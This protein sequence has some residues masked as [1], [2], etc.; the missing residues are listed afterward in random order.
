M[1][2]GFEWPSGWRALGEGE[3]AATFEAELRRELSSDHALHGLPASLLAR[4]DDRDDFLFS[5]NDARVAQV[6]LTWRQEHTGEWPK[7]RIF[8]DLL[9]WR[10][11]VG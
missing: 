2:S 5:L 6:H 1:I 4:R 7:A 8:R 9:E 3:A 10:S 11:L